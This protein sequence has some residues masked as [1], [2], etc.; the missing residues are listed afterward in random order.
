M[1]Y[2]AIQ[3]PCEDLVVRSRNPYTDAQR[4]PC[5]DLRVFI[6]PSFPGS[7]LLTYNCAFLFRKYHPSTHVTQPTTLCFATLIGNTC[8]DMASCSSIRDLGRFLGLLL[9]VQAILGICQLVK[10][11]TALPGVSAY[12]AA[13]GFPTSAFSYELITSFARLH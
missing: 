2:L 7:S 6:S 11:S 3:A 12:V 1:T 4:R 8:A 5:F 13:A 9:V 10:A